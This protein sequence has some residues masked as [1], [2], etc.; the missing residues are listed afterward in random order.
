MTIRFDDQV[1]IVTGAGNGL[2]KSYALELARRGAKVVVNDLG[3]E[4]D[5]SGKDPAV[6]QKVVDEIRAF[7]GTAIAN[8][9]SVTDD[10]GV[11]RLIDEAIGAFGRIDILVANAG[12]HRGAQFADMTVAEFQDV[13]E[14]HLLGTVKPLRAVWPHMQKQRYGRVVMTTSTIG[15]FGLGGDA[16]YCAGKM[17]VIGVLNTLR[18]EGEA[19]GI[20][21]NAIGPI[22]AT[23]MGRDAVIKE[24][25]WNAFAKDFSPDFVTPGVVYLASR[26]APNGKILTA[27]GGVYACAEMVGARGISLGVD[28]NADD[29]AKNWAA[30]SDFSQPHRFAD[31]LKHGDLLREMAGT[32]R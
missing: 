24:A 21:I 5:G 25:E 8:G 12:I 1:A 10:A 30:I 15:L 20:H 19:A 18:M 27:G 11:A 17:G 16:H 7:G 31:A 14:M 22:A 23:R 26:D 13:M 2:G 6:A 9:S 29:V 28:C 3:G 32:T 4:R